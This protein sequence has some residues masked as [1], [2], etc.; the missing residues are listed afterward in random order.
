MDFGGGLLC[1]GFSELIES[2]GLCLPPKLEFS[3]TILS[4]LRLNLV[5]PLL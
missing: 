2:V 4:F 3:A 5:S 1:L